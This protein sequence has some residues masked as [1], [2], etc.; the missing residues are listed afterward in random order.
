MS[1]TK[2]LNLFMEKTEAGED[3]GVKWQLP[4]I[5]IRL[6]LFQSYGTAFILGLCNVII[7]YK[8]TFLKAS[9]AS[10]LLLE[11]SCSSY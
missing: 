2:K 10:P 3:V 7:G 4:T 8:Y 11:Q 6:T 9:Q 5:S 1:M